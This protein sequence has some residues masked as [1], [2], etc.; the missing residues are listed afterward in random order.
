[1][2]QQIIIKGTPVVGANEVLVADSNSK[3]PAV[4]GSA[5]TAMAGGNITGTIPTARLDTGTTA[6]KLVVLGAS[7][8]PAVDGSLLTGIVS[9]TKSA[10]DPTISTNPSAGLGAEWVNHTTGKQFICTDAT[11]GANVWTC[12]GGGSGDVSPFHLHTSSIACFAAGGNITG[13]V[14]RAVIDKNVFASDGNSTDQG[15]LTA[16]V[17][18]HSASSSTTH[19]YNAGGYTG[20]P[21]VNVIDK[22]AMGS[23]ANATD[24]GDLTSVGQTGAGVTSTTHGYVAGGTYTSATRDVKKYAYASDGNATSSGDLISVARNYPVGGSSSDYGYIMGSYSGS[25]TTQIEKWNYASEAT[26][27]NVGSLAGTHAAASHASAGYVWGSGQHNTAVNTIEKM[28]T[29]SDSDS[30]D[31]GSDLSVTMHGTGI[32]NSSSTYGYAM[33]GSVSGNHANVVDKWPFDSSS[34]ATDVGNLTVAREGFMF[35]GN[36]L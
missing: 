15:D 32:G 1:M 13:D 5:V 2:A 18:G 8:L 7:G 28:S 30:V 27:A 10:S 17:R 4:D 31:S 22:F 11:A 6:N 35:S 36:Q 21:F 25:P 9:Y 29:T 23:P 12:S 19:G 24:V 14:N 20:A 3:I 26:T 34:T 16:A 33:G